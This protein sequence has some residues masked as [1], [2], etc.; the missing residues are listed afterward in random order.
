MAFLTLGVLVRQMTTVQVIGGG[1]LCAFSPLLVQ[2]ETFNG[3][4][5][6]PVA[7]DE[8]YVDGA[9][10]QLVYEGLDSLMSSAMP[11]VVTLGRFSALYSFRLELAAHHDLRCRCPCTE[12][13]PGTSFSG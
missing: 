10:R 12:C 9:A 7:V 13:L 4:H 11:A 1:G 2:G 5:G 3:S 6:H 8:K